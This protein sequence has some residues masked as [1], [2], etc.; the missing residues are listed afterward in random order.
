MGSTISPGV[1][2]TADFHHQVESL[3]TEADQDRQMFSFADS[4]LL[5]ES[6]GLD[7]SEVVDSPELLKMGAKRSAEMD[8]DAP[9]AERLRNWLDQFPWGSCYDDRTLVVAFEEECND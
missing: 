2:R 5:A 8:R 7:H 3:Q 9:S 1:R 4:R 6:L